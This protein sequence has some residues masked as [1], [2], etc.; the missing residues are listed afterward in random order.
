MTCFKIKTSIVYVKWLASL[1]AAHG[2]SSYLRVTVRRCSSKQVLLKMLPNSQINSSARVPLYQKEI[3]T[4]GCSCE[5]CEM[6]RTPFFQ[7]TLPV[8][9][10]VL[11]KSENLDAWRAFTLWLSSCL[12]QTFLAG[13]CLIIPS[14]VARKTLPAIY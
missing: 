2:W 11:I 12:T 6:L 5:F 14:N 3:L 7:G 9:A 10:S 4:H 1:T 13:N 8:A